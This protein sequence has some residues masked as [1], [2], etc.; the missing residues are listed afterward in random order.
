M[1]CIINKV[2]KSNHNRCRF[3]CTIIRS[4]YNFFLF[5]NPS[6]KRILFRIE[7]V[8]YYHYEYLK[9]WIYEHASYSIFTLL[10]IKLLIYQFS[11]SRFCQFTL[12]WT[13]HLNFIIIPTQTK[14]RTGQ[15]NGLLGFHAHAT[16]H[17]SFHPSDQ[18]LISRRKNKHNSHAWLNNYHC[19]T[20]DSILMSERHVQI[21]N[22]TYLLLHFLWRDS[23]TFS[24]THQNS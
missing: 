4:L 18:F 13:I 10:H 9:C 16:V 17:Y 6:T 3:K 2:V 21:G 1:Q 12:E 7:Y 19:W 20:L 11:A 5:N 24:C 14:S 15:I 22:L 23:H 8:R